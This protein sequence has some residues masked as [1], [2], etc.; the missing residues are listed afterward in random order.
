LLHELGRAQIEV[1]AQFV[2]H[3]A[4]NARVA[5]RGERDVSTQSTER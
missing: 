5:S 3:L 4:A 1:V 2:V